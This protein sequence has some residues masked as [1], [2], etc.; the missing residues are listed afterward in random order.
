MILNKNNY[1]TID[2][3]LAT[4]TPAS[5]LQLQKL[6]ELIREIAPAA[7]ET[8]KYLMPTFTLNGNLIHFAAFKN[9]IGLYPTPSP[10]LAYS[11]EL[12]KYKK[13]KGAIQFPIN[14]PLPLDIIRK[15]ILYRVNQNMQKTKLTK[16]SQIVN[17]K[18]KL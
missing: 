2:D 3:Y 17:K 12:S 7:Q 18:V 15:I 9:H 8:I 4:C 5:K 14:E 6:R 11:K 16:T 10:I 13:S 1:Q